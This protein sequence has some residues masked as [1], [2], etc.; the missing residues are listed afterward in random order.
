MTN[1]QMLF[2]FFIAIICGAGF[3]IGKA[4]SSF[5]FILPVALVTGF[6]RFRV[7]SPEDMAKFDKDKK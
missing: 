2:T 5:V 7:V 1:Q 4:L 6:F 3:N